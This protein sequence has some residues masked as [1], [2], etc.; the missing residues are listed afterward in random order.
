M[1]SIVH[2]V[3]LGCLLTGDGGLCAGGGWSDDYDEH[4]G[5]SITH[6]VMLVGSVMPLGLIASRGC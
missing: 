5:E 4:D 6:M 3:R 1:V 2:M